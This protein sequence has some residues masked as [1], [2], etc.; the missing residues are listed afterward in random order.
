MDKHSAAMRELIT[1]WGNATDTQVASSS[2]SSCSSSSSS[3]SPRDTVAS[4][5]NDS[6][7]RFEPCDRTFFQPFVPDTFDA[8]APMFR[9]PKPD[10]DGEL[11]GMVVATMMYDWQMLMHRALLRLVQHIAA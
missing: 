1:L 6:N 5:S 4:D 8:C 10:S 9:V 11:F 2:S 3:S 7:L